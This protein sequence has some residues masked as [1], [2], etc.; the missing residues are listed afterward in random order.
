MGTA[1]HAGSM[2]VGR[3]IGGLFSSKRPS[4]A[5]GMTSATKRHGKGSEYQYGNMTQPV[6]YREIPSTWT[7]HERDSEG[8]VTEKV[9]DHVAIQGEPLFSMNVKGLAGGPNW[10]PAMLDELSSPCPLTVMN[11]RMARDYRLQPS[12]LARGDGSGIGAVDMKAVADLLHFVGFLQTRQHPN[13]ESF[14]TSEPADTRV[15]TVAGYCRE[16]LDLWPDSATPGDSIGFLL[17][18][19]DRERLH[20]GTET[21]PRDAICSYANLS[22]DVERKRLKGDAQMEA[23]PD[24]RRCRFQLVPV[25]STASP[26]TARERG[27]DSALLP[28]DVLHTGGVVKL[29]TGASPDASGVSPDADGNQSLYAAEVKAYEVD[30]ED[31]NQ[32]VYTDEDGKGRAEYTTDLGDDAERIG[33]SGW[34]L[35]TWMCMYV[36]VGLV[37]YRNQTVMGVNQTREAVA[38]YLHAQAREAATQAVTSIGQFNPSIAPRRPPA[39]F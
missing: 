9:I 1:P 35:A 22:A 5:F 25:D 7:V 14:G 10:D 4:D 33:E 23:I 11:A 3:N 6:R 2:L 36:H 26:Y 38:R 34:G 39:L 30:Q 8:R 19:V 32:E 29:R 13:G 37:V 31:K 18:L 16:A 28:L 15:V 17:V 27:C 20:A 12:V 21:R 24:I